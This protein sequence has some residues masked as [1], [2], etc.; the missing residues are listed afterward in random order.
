M[1]SQSPFHPVCPQ[2]LWDKVEICRQSL[3]RWKSLSLSATPNLM[4]V[5]ILN[6][7]ILTEPLP[8]GANLLHGHPA[9]L[10]SWNHKTIW[11]GRDF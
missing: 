7:P 6:F 5:K 3:E 11:I 8:G 2:I 9:P 1:S 4:G 10:E